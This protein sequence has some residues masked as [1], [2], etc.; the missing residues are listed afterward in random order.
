MLTDEKKYL[1]VNSAG[2][3][4][5]LT[6]GRKLWSTLSAAATIFSLEAIGSARISFF[7]AGN[8]NGTFSARVWG[9][10]KGSNASGG[11]SDC[12]IEYLGQAASTLSVAV[13]AAA[14]GVLVLNSER[15]ADTLVWTVSTTATTPKGPMAVIETAYNEGAS[16]AYSP[17]DDTPAHLHLPSLGRFDGLILEFGPLT[18]ATGVNAL[19]H[20]GA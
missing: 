7:G 20:P 18:N 19:I 15:L 16:A 14:S 6:A 9:V 8:D 4:F 11:L 17:A 12:R 2:A 5:A 10:T 1:T 13:G 3:A